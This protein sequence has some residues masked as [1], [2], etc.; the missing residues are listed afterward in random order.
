M[1]KADGP[2]AYPLEPLTAEE[3]RAAGQGRGGRAGRSVTE[4]ASSRS[5]CREPPKERRR[6]PRPVSK[7][8]LT[9][10]GPIEPEE[11]GPTT[12][13]EHVLV[14]LSCN[15]VTPA[16]ESERSLLDAPV[17]MDILGVL[18]RR[19]FSRCLD[20]VVLSD[21]QLAIDELTRF[22]RAGGSGIVDCTV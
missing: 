10:L 17:T 12:M 22:R 13:H 3:I 5:R 2:L 7:K 1:D 19:P 6:N 16:E 11:L 20:N 9:V 8:I 14:D 21:E 4:S 18:R 15:F